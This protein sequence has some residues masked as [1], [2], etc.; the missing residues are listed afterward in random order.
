MRKTNAPTNMFGSDHFQFD[1]LV[2][3]ISHEMT[4][5]LFAERIFMEGVCQQTKI[6]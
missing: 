6:I 2:C 4:T 5:L 1:P 3:T